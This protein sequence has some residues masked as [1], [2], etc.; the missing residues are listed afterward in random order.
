MVIQA[1]QDA[2]R[3]HCQRLATIAYVQAALT[4]RCVLEGR[5]GEAWEYFPFWS[6]EEIREM[7]VEKVRRMMEGMAGA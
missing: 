3:L 5:M 1:R 7:R 6:E 2:E 4:A